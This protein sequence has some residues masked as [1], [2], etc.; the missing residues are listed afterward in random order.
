MLGLLLL[1]CWDQG[2]QAEGKAF[3][4]K[5]AGA[6][7]EKLGFSPYVFQIVVVGSLFS[8]QEGNDTD[9]TE[10]KQLYSLAPAQNSG[11]RISL[12][13]VVPQRASC[14]KP[15]YHFLL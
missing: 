6:F 15:G 12:N 10:G 3:R 9:D 14:K 1:R 7:P 11:L 4:A 8:K 5:E 2:G 13:T